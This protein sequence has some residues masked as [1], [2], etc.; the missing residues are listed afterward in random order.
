[1]K[2]TVTIKDLIQKNKQEILSN[3]KAM[4]QIEKKIEEKHKGKV[5]SR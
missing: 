1:M 3:K 5:L 2:K 4:E